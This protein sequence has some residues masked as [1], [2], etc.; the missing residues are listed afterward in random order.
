[1][2]WGAS[3]EGRVAERNVVSARS[4]ATNHKN[5]NR[6]TGSQPTDNTTTG[7]AIVC[8]LEMISQ[9]GTKVWGVVCGGGGGIEHQRPEEQ[10]VVKWP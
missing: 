2:W 6:G 10:Q 7:P 3:W 8:V 4:R 5:H 9:G 1:M